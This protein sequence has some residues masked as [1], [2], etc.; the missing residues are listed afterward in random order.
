MT[1]ARIHRWPIVRPLGAGGMGRVFEVRDRRGQPWAL[2]TLPHTYEPADVARLRREADLMQ[3]VDHPNV[4]R[5]ACIDLD[6]DPPYLIAELLRGPTLFERVSAGDELDEDSL[7]ELARALGRGLVALHDIGVV[8]RDLTPRNVIL[9]DRGA[10]LIDFGVAIAA[11]VTQLTQ[12]DATPGTP[13]WLAPERSHNVPATPAADIYGWARLVAYAATASV[14]PDLDL[15]ERSLLPDA[16]REL[17]RRGLHDD[18]R[19]RPLDTELAEWCGPSDQPLS[20]LPPVRRPRS[21]LHL[22]GLAAGPVVALTAAASVVLLAGE[23]PQQS[24][25]ETTVESTPGP[26]FTPSVAPLIDLG[27]PL[28]DDSTIVS[29]GSSGNFPEGTAYRV[30]TA[31]TRVEVADRLEQGL[32]DTGW[33]GSFTDYESPTETT[34]GGSVAVSSDG[35]FDHADGRQLLVI[36]SDDTSEDEVLLSIDI[37]PGMAE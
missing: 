7:V 35:Y 34:P 24:S 17:V 28:P 11:D 4:A 10:C 2:K 32:V 16:L 18:P 6:A 5:I 3:R 23:D 29:V 31:G 22:V 19:A 36:I 15:I 27:V 8:H 33:I 20:P 30:K 25:S 1:T 9:A 13:A 26:A 12:V 21:R 14:D 37:S